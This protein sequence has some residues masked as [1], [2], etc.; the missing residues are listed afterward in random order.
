MDFDAMSTAGSVKS[1]KSST[2]RVSR[3][4]RG[5]KGSKGSKKGGRRASVEETVPLEEPKQPFDLDLVGVQAMALPHCS[6]AMSVRVCRLQAW[7]SPIDAMHTLCTCGAC[8]LL[9]MELHDTIPSS[10]RP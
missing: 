3:T 6:M 8:S 5:S 4:S 2:S 9:A 1:H 10:I 7:L